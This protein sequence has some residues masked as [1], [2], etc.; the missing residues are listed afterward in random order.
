MRIVLNGETVET[1]E[2]LTVADLVETHL[3]MAGERQAGTASEGGQ[4]AGSCSPG[5]KR[6]LAVAVNAEVVPRS[7]WSEFRLEEG[8]RVEILGASQGG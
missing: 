3:V 4:D 2:G 5:N 1:D 7:A 8:D 6:G